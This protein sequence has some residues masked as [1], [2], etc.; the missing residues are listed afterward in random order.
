MDLMTAL[1]EGLP[2]VPYGWDCRKALAGVEADTG[3]A[4]INTRQQR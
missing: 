2:Q 1:F 4:I 3:L